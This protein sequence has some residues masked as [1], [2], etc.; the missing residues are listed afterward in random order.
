MQ[1]LSRESSRRHVEMQEGLLEQ[2]I[3][4]ESSRL[5]GKKESSKHPIIEPQAFDPEGAED[6]SG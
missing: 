5:L 6:M 2:T 4:K 1:F 3:R